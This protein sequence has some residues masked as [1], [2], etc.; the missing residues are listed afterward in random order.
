MK[1]SY[2]NRERLLQCPLVLAGSV[3]QVS[4]QTLGLIRPGQGL[5]LDILHVVV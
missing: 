4:S 3:Q 2:L 1:I 5:A